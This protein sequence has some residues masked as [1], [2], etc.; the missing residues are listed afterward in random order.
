MNSLI[1]CSFG[2]LL[3]CVIVLALRIKEQ[4]ET[5]QR[6]IGTRDA[7]HTSL[8]DY[9]QVHSVMRNEMAH[10]SARLMSLEERS[11]SLT[12]QRSLYKAQ[13]TRYRH[14]WLKLKPK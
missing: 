4:R 9:I 2:I 12:A 3:I 10:L 6:L 14:L 5:I 7:A 13:A 1:Y 11:K 8:R